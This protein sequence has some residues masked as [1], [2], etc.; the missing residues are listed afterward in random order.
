HVAPDETGPA[1]DHDLRSGH[2]GRQNSRSVIKV[3]SDLGGGR[4][5]RPPPA[6]D[7]KRGS[8]PSPSSPRRSSPL[9]PGRRSDRIRSRRF[10][11][12]RPRSDRKST[13]LNS[14][15]LVISY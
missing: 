6:P 15:H 9:P 11:A 10:L 7:G 14:S 3:A 8:S 4:G 12:R 13:R 5:G 1:R 2:A